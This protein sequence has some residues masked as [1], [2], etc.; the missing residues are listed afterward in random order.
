M[1]NARILTLVLAVLTASALPAA[2]KEADDKSAT[3]PKQ[4][5]LAAINIGGAFPETETQIGLFGE[6]EQS[7]AKT[8]ARIDRAAEDDDISGLILT[9]RTPMVGRGKINELRA[10]IARARKAGTKV[11]ADIQMG[12]ASD[13]LI[14][15]ACDEIILP[16]GG[17]IV[18]PG[19]RAEVMFFK[20]MLEKIGVKADFLQVGDF[21][22]AAEPYVRSE[23][24]P[25][26]RQQFESL[27]DDLYQQM[28]ENVAADRKLLPEQVRK[29]VDQGLFTAQAAK[30][31][32]LIDR[33]AYADELKEQIKKENDADKLS[34]I[35]KYGKKKMDADFSGFT[36]MIK[37]MNLMM[38]IE[39]SSGRTYGDKI[40]VVY[41]LGPI[42]SGESEQGLFAGS[43]M[44]SDTIVKALQTAEK[45]KKVRA[46][47]LRV[48][49][50]GGSALASDQIWRQVALT[51]KPLIASMGD[52]AAS[53]GYYISMGAQQIFAEPGT[54]TGSIG[55]VGGKMALGGTFNKLGINTQTVARGE[56]SGIFSS[57]KPFSPAEREALM[58]LMKDTYQQFTTKAAEGRKMKIEDLEKLAQG[59]V[60]TGRQAQQLGLVD[61]VGTLRDAIMAAKVAA[62]LNKDKKVNLMI[63]PKPK[64]FFEQMLGGPEIESRA[65]SSQ[66]R[67]AVPQLAA[68]LADIEQLQHLF[69]EPV[70]VVLPFRVRIH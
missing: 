64:S 19:V 63:L 7:L 43:T 41:A 39:P 20:D 16:P 65:L 34:V 42:M 3:K 54:L 13:Y 33:V 60:Y 9:L 69:A 44:G 17:A 14:A 66:L 52:T 51:K 31:A 55:V 45:D 58:R 32:G 18:L 23:M 1:R 4:I 8:I 5:K 57:D 26:L 25:E 21:K 50:P 38:G 10:A 53:G 30:E 49:S 6:L 2:A 29:L 12:M 36:G 28:I 62:G 46:I 68:P 11:Y 47:V 48:D 40:A 24:S 70:N 56:N 27:I 67:N 61:K 37:L 35:K 22:G 59:K 15:C